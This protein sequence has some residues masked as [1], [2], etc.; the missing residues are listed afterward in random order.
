MTFQPSA[1]KWLLGTSAAA[2]L[3]MGLWWVTEIYGVPQVRDATVQAMQQPRLKHDGAEPG[4]DPME[5]PF[6][7]CYAGAYGPLVVGADYQ[8][9]NGPRSGKGTALYLWCFGHTFHIRDMRAPGR[10]MPV[11][12]PSVG[13]VGRVI[14]PKADGWV[15]WRF[16]LLPKLFDDV[17][18]QHL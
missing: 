17:M 2:A 13:G 3:Y 4:D 11:A 6:Y 18:V 12:A 14:C 9:Q 1:K 5:G 8:W 7:R 15:L 10:I 16:R